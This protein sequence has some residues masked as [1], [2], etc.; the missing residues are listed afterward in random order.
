M[1]QN[2]VQPDSGSCFLNNISR[3]GDSA[4]WA[5]APLA[6]ELPAKLLRASIHQFHVELPQRLPLFLRELIKNSIDLSFQK[7]AK[8]CNPIRSSNSPLQ[9]RLQTISK[10]AFTTRLAFKN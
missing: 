9:I 5:P 7:A 1:L 4:G 10:T 8:E 2:E 3:L 6:C